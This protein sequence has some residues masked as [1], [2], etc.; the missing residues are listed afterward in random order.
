MT[1]NK[2]TF[3]TAGKEVAAAFKEFES[4]LESALP[5]VEQFAAVA[6]HIPAL[7][8]VNSFVQKVL[9][10]VQAADAAEKAVSNV[11]AATA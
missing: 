10:V 5:Y 9:P 6:L 7:A 3:E 4:I 1:I 11:P 2:Q 8:S